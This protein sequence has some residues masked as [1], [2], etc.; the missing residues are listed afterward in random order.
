[1]INGHTGERDLKLKSMYAS[2]LCLVLICWQILR[3][4]HEWSMDFL[5]ILFFFP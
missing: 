2:S 4:D 1:M 3:C 5:K